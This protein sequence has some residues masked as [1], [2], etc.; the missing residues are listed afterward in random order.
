MKTDMVCAVPAD[1]EDNVRMMADMIER[2]FPYDTLAGFIDDYH[3]NMFYNLK[4]PLWINDALI[5]ALC[6]RICSQHRT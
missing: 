4:P 2:K 1:M 5:K 3:H 6:D